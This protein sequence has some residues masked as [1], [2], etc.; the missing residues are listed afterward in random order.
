MNT[1]LKAFIAA[2]IFCTIILGTE[3][4]VNKSQTTKEPEKRYFYVSYDFASVNHQNRGNGAV[5]FSCSG[6]FPTKNLIDSVVYAGLTYERSCYQ[7]IVI[8][9]IFEFKDKQDYYDFDS[10]YKGSLDT[11]SVKLSC[12]IKK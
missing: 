11:N 10:G 4:F 6:G 7:P 3:Y 9:N 1:I 12:T 2:C 8:K 5:W